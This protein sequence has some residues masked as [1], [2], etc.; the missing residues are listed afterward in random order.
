[1]EKL[2]KTLTLL[3]FFIS[4]TDIWCQSVQVG[5]I[6]FYGPRSNDMELKNCLPFKEN[7]IIN[8]DSIGSSFTS[9][10]EYKQAILDWFKQTQPKIKQA[11]L[12]F[13][14]CVDQKGKW[15]VYVGVDTI[16]TQ[17]PE[18][19]K[20]NDIK[21]PTEI[22][23]VY[24]SVNDLTIVA[25]QHGEADEDD[26]NGH[27]L[28]TYLPARKL[29]EKFIKYADANLN[30]LREVLK[31]SKYDEQRAVAATVI[32]YYH[33][34]AEIIKDLLEAVTDADQ[35]VRNNA[36]RAIGIIAEYAQSRP[37]LKI[38]IAADPFIKMMNS[39]L[40]TDRNKGV[41]V[42]R[43]LSSTRDEKLLL[44][45]KDE[46]LESL[47][48]MA[49]WKSD[50]HSYVGY[51]ILGRIAGWTEEALNFDSFNKN[52]NKSE[53]INKMLLTIK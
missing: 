12:S 4:T 32:G 19:I 43:V 9:V 49:N 6:D 36:T 1:M 30:L 52:K 35:N 14:C 50:G 48:D 31:T 13:I 10:F 8:L 51:L 40:W 39:I 29:Q 45:L 3:F 2:S 53:L 37:N 27:S 15:I 7:D 16:L 44:K 25:I 21:L 41:S 46:A 28:I 17:I 11:E 23:S 42:L 22:T 24:D 33:N 5:I 47:I 38:E 18:R 34:K 26:S 20:A